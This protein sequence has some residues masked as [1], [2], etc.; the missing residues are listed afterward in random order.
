MVRLLIVSNRLPVMVR[1][2][3]GHVSVAPSTGALAT[4]LRRYHE[5][6][7]GLWIGWPGDTGDLDSDQGMTVRRQ[8]DE[9]RMVPVPVSAEEIRG[10]DEGV[11]NEALWPVFHSLVGQALLQIPDFSVYERVNER[12]AEV[13]ASCYRSGDTI[14]VHGYQLM[15][16]PALIR[17]HIAHATIG[18]FLHIPFPPVEVFC[19]LPCRETLLTGL[20]GADLLGFQAPSYM[21]NFTST[22]TRLLGAPT[23]V[24]AVSWHQRPVRL[25]VFPAGVDASYFAAAAR[26]EGVIAQ[27]EALRRSG[28]MQILVGIDRLDYTKGIPR[29]LLA[30]EKLLHDHPRFREQVQLIQVAVPSRTNVAAYQD[31]R[32]QV[33][34]LVGR[35][36]GAF[37]TGRWTPV[38][39]LYRALSQRDLVALYLAADVMLVTPIR[40]GMNLV[41]KEFVACRVDE[42]G[43]LVLSE[44]TGAATELAEA[45]HVNPYDID[46]VAEA[47]HRALTMPEGERQLR[48]RSLRRRVSVYDL[49]RWVGSFLAELERSASV[50]HEQPPLQSPP[51]VLCEV[52]R[53]LR[54][55]ARVVMLLDYDGT[56]VSLA[57]SPDLAAPDAEILALLRRLGQHPSLDVHVISGRS[58]RTLER[59]LGALPLGLYAEHGAWSRPRGA[60]EWTPLELDAMAWRESVLA[61]LDDFAAR[62]PGALVEEK[63][64]GLA[65]HYRMADPD[66]GM[67]QANELMLHLTTLLAN[68][69]VEVLHGH[70]VIELRPHGVHKG[71]VVSSIME[72]AHPDWLLMAMGD[73]RTD[74]DLFAALPPTAV[75]IHV[76]PTAS[77]AAIRLAD[78]TAVRKFLDAL[79][80]GGEPCG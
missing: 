54:S 9:L 55:A 22:V 28:G 29:R 72:H 78:V 27:A 38:Q 35:I 15:L 37:A 58:H 70:K 56:L 43:V 13:V 8:L 61:V 26:D 64:F 66:Y 34:G 52:V 2:D 42:R 3:G 25:G 14:W 68:E 79:V 10:Y 1:V 75:A 51:D 60:P 44:F 17:K 16:V 39:Y 77:R 53:R 11:S 73:D 32:A 62:T 40:D 80:G 12:F 36:N 18:L 67:S 48:M 63:A 20:L 59:W 4:G 5:R 74:E 65:W 7:Q 57:P 76:G 50:R 69:P 49:S 6:S 30:Y 33:D 45:I 71:R 19:A 31:L 46:R 21:R 47:Y 41:A 23:S 24:D